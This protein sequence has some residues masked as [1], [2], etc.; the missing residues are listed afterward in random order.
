VCCS[1]CPTT[2]NQIDRENIII[3]I[4]IKSPWDVLDII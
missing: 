2:T 3:I 1:S 4:I